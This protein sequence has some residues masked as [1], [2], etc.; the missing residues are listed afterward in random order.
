M[1]AGG[2]GYRLQLTG[3]RKSKAGN[4]GKRKQIMYPSK[5]SAVVN[6]LYLGEA[7]I[8]AATCHL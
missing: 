8:L 1:N 4:D 2:T 3:D 5:E 6:Y 7:L